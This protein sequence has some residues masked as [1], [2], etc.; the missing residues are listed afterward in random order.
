MYTYPQAHLCVHSADH[1]PYIV[2][3]REDRTLLAEAISGWE[4]RLLSVHCG[5]GKLRGASEGTK[6]R[7]GWVMTKRAGC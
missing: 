7:E 1:T 2:G 3:L 6:E 4:V 5:L